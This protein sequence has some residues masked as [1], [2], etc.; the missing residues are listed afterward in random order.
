MPTQTISTPHLHIPPRRLWFG[1]AGAAVAWALHGTVC[2]IISAKACQNGIG[3]LGAL[4]P[5]GVR[6]L[7]AGITLGFLA[8]AVAGGIISFRNWRHVAATND[9]VHAESP[10]RE[11]FMS[12]GGVFVSVAFVVGI[13][14]AGLPLIFL[15]VCMKAR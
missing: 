13:I 2:E 10:Q 4:S 1:T 6:W 8:I 12:L 11:Q 7:L 3:S 15:D 5:F 9:L 14:W